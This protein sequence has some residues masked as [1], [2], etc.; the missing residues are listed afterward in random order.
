VTIARGAPWGERGAR[1]VGTVDAADDA[2]AREVVVAAHRAGTAVPPL[3]LQRGDLLRTLGHPGPTEERAGTR[4]GP[5]PPPAALLAPA[6]LG[7]AVLDG[8]EH[9]FVAHVVARRSWWRGRLVAVMNAQFLG[10]WDVAPR[11]HPNDGRLDVLDV[12]PELSVRDRWRARRRL[13]AG[14]HV[15]HPAIQ[16]RSVTTWG[17][18]FDPALDVWLDGEP[19]GRVRHLEVRVVPDALL[20]V[21][22]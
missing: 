6:D 2:A 8:T 22:V 7:V 17:T 19:V 18:T 12:A 14:A 16:V 4:P 3:H 11:S 9:P 20:L 1:P 10:A 15:P 21:A 5:P 13:P